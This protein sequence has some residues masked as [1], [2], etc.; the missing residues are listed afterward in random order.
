MPNGLASKFLL[1]LAAS[2][3]NEHQRTARDRS[4]AAAVRRSRPLRRSVR[5]TR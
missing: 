5:R 4:Q 1:D 3:Q 2:R